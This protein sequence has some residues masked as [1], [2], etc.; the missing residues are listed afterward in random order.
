MD[1]KQKYLKYKHKYLI[2]KDNFNGGI[3]DYENTD[4][5]I[6]N[7]KYIIDFIN[8]ERCAF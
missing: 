8:L 2:L 1:Y 4:N 7:I 6:Q 3:I 5:I